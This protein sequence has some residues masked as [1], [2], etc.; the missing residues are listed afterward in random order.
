MLLISSP[1]HPK[2]PSTS[3]LELSRGILPIDH[4]QYHQNSEASIPVSSRDRGR[5]NPQRPILHDRHHEPHPPLLINRTK[6]RRSRRCRCTDHSRR[7]TEPVFRLT[8]NILLI[9]SYSLLHSLLLLLLL[10]LPFPLRLQ[11]QFPFQ[12]PLLVFPLPLPLPLL[13][14]FLILT[15]TPTIHPVRTPQRPPNILSYPSLQLRGCM[16]LRR[17]F[18]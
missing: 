5:S 2:N 11:L 3:D 9:L 14:R 17:L 8:P 12:I 6:P 16:S 13:L 10:L 4:Y 18:P 7:N 1:Y 15:P